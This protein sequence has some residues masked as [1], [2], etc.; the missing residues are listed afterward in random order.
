MESFQVVEERIAQQDG[1]ETLKGHLM[2]QL[3]IFIDAKDESHDW[4]N[5]SRVFLD[6]G[7]AMW[8]CPRCCGIIARE[9]DTRPAPTWKDLHAIA[10]TGGGFVASL[11]TEVSAAKESSTREATSAVL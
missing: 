9:K 2:R 5:L 4:G 7:S 6:E 11:K 8:C 1:E 3:K 10:A